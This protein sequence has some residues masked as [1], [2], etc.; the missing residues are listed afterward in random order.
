MLLYQLT[1]GGVFVI[2]A[3]ATKSSVLVAMAA[4][5][6]TMAVATIIF[7]WYTVKRLNSIG[8]YGALG[9]SVLENSSST[10]SYLIEELSNKE[11]LQKKKRKSSNVEAIANNSSESKGM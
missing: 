2:N 1:L 7:W 8:Y 4:I 11:K 6:I 10:T 5:A 9:A 3:A